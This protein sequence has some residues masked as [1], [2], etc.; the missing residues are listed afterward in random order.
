MLKAFRL[1]LRRASSEAFQRFGAIVEPKGPA[2]PVNNGTATRHDVDRF[3]AADAA[4][5]FHLVTSVYEADAQALPRPITLLERHTQSR[6]LIAPIS[7]GG[8]LVI[9]CLSG[10]DG[11]TPDLR[12]LAG[13]R[14]AGTQGMIY[15]PGVWHH[16]IFALDKPSLFLVQSW[17]NGTERDCEIATI[18]PH[19]VGSDTQEE[20][21]A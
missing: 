16:P 21:G 1:Q 4:T 15:R 13:F 19:L 10:R 7:A 20:N 8:H 12:T 6:Q 11:N 2:I 14:F 17:Q 9:V 5:G 3:A 18:D